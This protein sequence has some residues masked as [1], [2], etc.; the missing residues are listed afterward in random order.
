MKKH[1][2]FA[3]AAAALMTCACSVEPLD[4]VDVQ[5][6]EKGEITV[7]TAG[8]APSDETRTVR[9]PDGKVFWSPGDA[10]SVVREDAPGDHAKFVT[11]ITEP[12]PT[13]DFMGVLPSGTGMIWAVYPYREDNYLKDGVFM[14]TLPTRQEAVAGSFADNVFVSA[15]RF[16]DAGSPVQFQHVFSGVKFTVL[17]PG[18]RRVTLLPTTSNIL[19]GRFGL[20]DTGS[21]RL[22]ITTNGTADEMS[23]TAELFAPEGKTLEP[24]AAYHIVMRPAY[25]IGGF[26]LAFEKKD[27]TVA[28]RK[29]T[30]S[31]LFQNGHFVTMMGADRGL[32]FE[33]FFEISPS[34]CSVSAEGGVFKVHVRISG[35]YHVDTSNCDWIREVKTVGNPGLPDGADIYF[36]AEPN[37]GQERS[38]LV[39]ICSD[40]KDGTCHPVVVTPPG[41]EG[42]KR[43]V[44]HA[45][46]LH[47][48]ATWCVYCPAL[49]EVLHQVKPVLGDR[50]E[51][52]SL[53]EKN[54]NYGIS[55]E[56][57]LFDYYYAGGYPSLFLDG[58]YDLSDMS[59]GAE[60]AA[61]KFS[62]VIA[63]KEAFFPAVTAVAL[64]STVS[65]RTV[66]VRAEVFANVGE[67]YKI[68]AY[69]VESGIIGQQS[70]LSGTIP[71]YVHDRVAR[72]KL[73][74]SAT[75]D[76]FT[77]SAG[78]TKT[79]NY[80]ATVPSGCNMDNMEVIAYV[81]RK[82]ASDSPAGS[83]IPYLDW[84]V[85]N[86]RNA[87]LGA[88]AALEVE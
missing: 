34:E 3:A 74:S 85:D 32:V 44:H 6:E 27:G 25:L 64:S 49:D 73:T 38:G 76:Y 21:G 12:A 57:E 47:F 56:A 26:T 29:I 9:Q 53:Y 79:F 18:I 72:V 42:M 55:S 59:A 19:T 11:D 71:E 66:N 10:I 84:Y 87:A 69:L 75:G 45:L 70:S 36:A 2:L 68:S 24:G 28:Y 1:F 8:F 63:E 58:R 65:G 16:D 48:T 81:E 17:E 33:N 88:T 62:G 39:S 78:E 15:A 23:E 77:V 67:R 52:I 82:Y 41:G 13:A 54:G 37:Y 60:T 43:I 35:D 80:T 86:S 46:G 31:Q 51:F 22:Y 20:E 7:L 50:F 5:P 4:V 30:K 14:T 61:E 40:G 83:P